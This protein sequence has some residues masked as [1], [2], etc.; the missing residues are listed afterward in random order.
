MRFSEETNPEPFYQSI[1]QLFLP[2]RSDMELKPQNFE[3]FEQYY[4][5]GH[6]TFSNGSR[7]SVKLLT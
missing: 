6:V 2:Y 7:H 1:M 4:K 5:N 3:T